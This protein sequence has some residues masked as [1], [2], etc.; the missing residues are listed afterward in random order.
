MCVLAHHLY[1]H[2]NLLRT[3]YLKLFGTGF[4]ALGYLSVAVFFFLSGYGLFASFNGRPDSIKTFPKNKILPFYLSNVI[5]VLIYSS[6]K[7]LIL[8]ELITFPELVRSLAF[9]GAVIDN[10]WY[11]QVQLVYY[12]MFFFVFRKMTTEGW[13][14]KILFLNALYVLG[15]VLAGFSTLYYE[16]TLIFVLGMQWYARRKDI[17]SVLEKK[18]LAIW[19]ASAALFAGCYGLSKYQGWMLRGVS[20]FFFI[21][22]VLI[23]LRKIRIKNKITCF[24]GKISFEIYVMQ[25]LFF[26]LFHSNKAKIDSPYLYIVMVTFATFVSA[27][28]IHPV[29]RFIYKSCRDT[30][31]TK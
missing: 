10:G 16:R 12:F 30:S 7:T 14:P 21:P 1:Q 15:C 20:Y 3:G 22:T 28:L 23:P 26:T 11:I 9:G 6:F 24:L 13:L 25:G 19:I 5:L 18:G 8:K 2:S 4:Q 17:D 31:D 27:Y 29:F